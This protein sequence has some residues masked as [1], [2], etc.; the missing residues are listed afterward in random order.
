MIMV[1]G[2]RRG[3][4]II[5]K[6]TV[7]ERNCQL[8]ERPRVRLSDCRYAEIFQVTEWTNFL[9]RLF[10]RLFASMFSF[11]SLGLIPMKILQQALSVLK[12]DHRQSIECQSVFC[13]AFL[14]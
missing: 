11:L 10:I 4:T 3:R 7:K 14:P 5:N 9:G 2:I 8:K 13:H 12:R 1:M 6:K